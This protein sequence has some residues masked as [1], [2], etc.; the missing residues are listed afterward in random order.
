MTDEIWLP[1]VGFV[2]LYEVSNL[3]RI[4]SLPRPGRINP[5]RLYGGKML[6]PVPL[7]KDGYLV[8]SLCGTALKVQHG[9]HQVVA[10][11]FYGLPPDGYVCC[12]NNGI[13]E[14]CR[15]ENLRWGTLLDNSND[16]ALHGTLP[17]GSDSPNSKLNEH[18][19]KIIRE[20]PENTVELGRRFGVSNVTI[21]RIKK[22]I[23]WRHI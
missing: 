13:K 3:G 7:K 14:D 9:L 17:L 15:S 10:Q 22:R 16:K 8:V 12:H 1:V 23:T 19:V 5:N 20:S 4:R 2:G 18:Q 11:A 6:S 21:G